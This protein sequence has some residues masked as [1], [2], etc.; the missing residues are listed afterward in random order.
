MHAG[1]LVVAEITVRRPRARVYRRT[2]IFRVTLHARIDVVGGGTAMSPAVASTQ[3]GE[4]ERAVVEHMWMCVCACEVEA[5]S[6]MHMGG[7]DEE[8]C[9]RVHQWKENSRTV[10]MVITQIPNTDT[11]THAAHRI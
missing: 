2:R 10:S 6:Q 3:Q 8:E 7:C 1:G 9:I 4:S 5:M 11:H